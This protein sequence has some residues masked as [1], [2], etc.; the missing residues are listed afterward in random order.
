MNSKNKEAR[1]IDTL[2]PV[3]NTHRLVVDQGLVEADLS[4]E[5]K[6]YSLFYQLSHITRKPTLTHDDRLDVLQMAVSYWTEEPKRDEEQAKKDYEMQDLDELLNWYD[7]MG[8]NY[9]SIDNQWVGAPKRKCQ[10]LN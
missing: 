8:I 5:N 1:I 9:R 2:E 10:A 7:S 4:I 3:L 6:A